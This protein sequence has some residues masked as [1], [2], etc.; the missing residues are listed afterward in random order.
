FEEFFTLQLHLCMRHEELGRETG[1]SFNA[2]EQVLEE[3]QGALPWPL[4]DAQRRVVAEIYSDMRQPHPMNRL[5][6][7][8]V[9]SGKTAVAACALYLAHRDG[10]QGALMA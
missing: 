5:L 1:I 9:G 3:L 7:G 4:T 8:D 2:N 6:Q 10:Y